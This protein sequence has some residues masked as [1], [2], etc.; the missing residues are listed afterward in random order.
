[1]YFNFVAYCIGP[2]TIILDLKVSI[3]DVPL[4]ISL[5][6]HTP[7]RFSCQRLWLKHVPEVTLPPANLSRL[8]DTTVS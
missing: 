7:F 5:Q 6:H 3:D 4:G 8:L 2:I 1:M